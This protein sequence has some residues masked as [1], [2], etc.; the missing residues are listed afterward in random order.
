MLLS[1]Y[2]AGSGA[3]LVETR[4]ERRFL[5]ALLAELPPT[6]EVCRVAAP[7]GGLVNVR[8][9]RPENVAGLFAGYQWAAAS[10]GRVLVV[11]DWHVL[12]NAPGHWRALSEGLPALRQ[13]AGAGDAD[14]ASL[15]VFV[16]PAWNLTPENPLKGALPLLP[17]DPPSR[18]DLREIAEQL[19]PLNGDADAVADALAGLSADVAEQAAAECLA[20][21]QGWNVEHLRQARRQLL[22]DAGLELWPAVADLGGLGGF[23]SYAETEVIPWLRDAQLSV[24]RILCAGVPG[25]GKSYCS[26]WLAHR[27]GCEC[28]R[29]SIPALKAGIVGS[30]EA[31]LRRALRGIDALAAEAPLVV[32]LDEIDTVAREGMDGGTSSGMFAE[33]LTWLQ[34]STAQAVV[35]ATLNRL[36]KLDAALESRFQGRFFFDLPCASERQAVAKIHFERL[37]CEHVEVASATVA[38]VCQGFSSREIAEALVPSV[39]RQTQRKPLPE[40]I[41]HAAKEMTPA[42]TTQAQQL[43]QMRQAAATL[44]RA[45]DPEIDAERIG[46]RIG[47]LS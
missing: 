9:G 21:H 43:A 10:P 44:R 28:V 2:R 18:E 16:A 8:T 46:R 25:V 37:H 47:G 4:E 41:Q 38:Q 22:K 13:P 12:C 27:L 11:F 40:P 45:N 33:L 15:V 31:N 14:A 6:A 29:L 39:A 1:H 17:F 34:E 23:R 24:R 7:Q 32:V 20:A 5:R 35:I 30:S 26:R 19:Y 36:D 42:S 3:V